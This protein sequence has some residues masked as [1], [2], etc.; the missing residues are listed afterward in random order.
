[1]IQEDQRDF[2]AIESLL[3]TCAEL[4]A[5]LDALSEECVDVTRLLGV[6][7]PHLRR[8]VAEQ[9]RRTQGQLLGFPANSRPDEHEL[10]EKFRDHSAAMRRQIK[11]AMEYFA[12]EN[13]PRHLPRHSLSLPPPPVV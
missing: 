12:E 8:E 13:L 10:I 1:M 2:F 7:G 11:A 5:L 6:A 3:E 9:S 4:G